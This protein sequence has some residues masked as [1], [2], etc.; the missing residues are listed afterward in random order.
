MKKTKLTDMEELEIFD[1]SLKDFEYFADFRR[2]LS[3]KGKGRRVPRVRKRKARFNPLTDLNENQFRIKYRYTKENLRR[4]IEVVRDD[5][6][7][8]YYE[9]LKREQVPIDLQ[10]LSAVRLWGG[11]EV[12]LY[13]WKSLCMYNKKFGA[14]SY[15]V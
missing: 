7:I 2:F 1:R 13:N 12:S 5:L 8:D 11:T 15:P 14:K 6:E 9:P 4:I 3:G 10:I